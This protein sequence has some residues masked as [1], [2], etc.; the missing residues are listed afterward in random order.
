MHTCRNAGLPG[1]GM[2]SSRSISTRPRRRGRSGTTSER[3]F[4]DYVSNRSP[5]FKAPRASEAAIDL[6]MEQPNLIGPSRQSSSVTSD[7]T[8][9]LRQGQCGEQP[10]HRHSGW[11]YPP[12]GP[13]TDFLS[14]GG[15]NA[16]PI[17]RARLRRA[18]RHRRINTTFTDSQNRVAQTWARTPT[19]SEFSLK[20]YR[21]LDHGGTGCRSRRHID[22]FDAVSSRWPRPAR[23]ARCWRSFRRAS[24]SQPSRR[25]TSTPC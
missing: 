22:D 19:A 5:V 20:L 16:G 8:R 9:R 6:M 25:R 23:L 17:R 3:R 24:S 18:F 7:S 13:G 14:T 4:L 1:P 15:T 11:N 2:T 10:S 12:E 21:E